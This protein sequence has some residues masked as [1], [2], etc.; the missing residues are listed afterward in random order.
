MKTFEDQ[1]AV[2]LREHAATL[3]GDATAPRG[4]PAGSGDARRR[5]APARPAAPTS[6]ARRRRRS[7]RWP[8]L[9]LPAA[10]LAAVA[11]V[12]TLP[13]ER[14]TPP[15]SAAA[16]LRTAATAAEREAPLRPGQQLYIRTRYQ[17]R[18]G[19]GVDERWLRADGSGRFVRREHGR[20]VESGTLKSELAGTV[21]VGALVDREARTMIAQGPGFDPAQLRT[22][23]TYRVLHDVL[24]SAAPGRVRADAIRELASAPGLRVLQ[25]A[26]DRVLLAARV[27]DVEFRARI[28]TGDG[29]VLALERVLLRRSR[30]IPGAPGVVDRSVFEAVRRL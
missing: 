27:G 29:R 6:P 15:A 16:L 4:A 3:A 14:T 28:D 13:S 19:T 7:R 30:Q 8:L 5:G 26:G 24:E 1:L 25:R 17:G 18:I 22:Y 12:L 23:A 9:A 21:D 2:A 20:V 10:A 11:L